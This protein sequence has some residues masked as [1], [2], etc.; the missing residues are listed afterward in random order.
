MTESFCESGNG[1]QFDKRRVIYQLS[2]N[3]LFKE[4][5]ALRS[6]LMKILHIKT[7]IVGVFLCSLLARE[8][9][10]QFAPNSARLFLETM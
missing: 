5:T 10:N 8:P 2:E 4:N 7:E 6:Q 1:A 3:K 9:I